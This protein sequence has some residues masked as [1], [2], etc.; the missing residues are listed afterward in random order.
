VSGTLG[1]VGEGLGAEGGRS[2]G[3]GR[4]DREEGESSAE[5][6]GAQAVEVEATVLAGR[7][8]DGVTRDRALI[9]LI[10]RVV[11]AVSSASRSE[12]APSARASASFDQAKPAAD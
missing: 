6:G 10:P 3:G 12:F 9:T 8:P 7:T 11:G 4:G 5:A 2:G 1:G